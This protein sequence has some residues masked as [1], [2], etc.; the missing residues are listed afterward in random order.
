MLPKDNLNSNDLRVIK[1]ARTKEAINAAAAAGF[2]PLVKPGQPLQPL[3][4]LPEIHRK[5]TVLQNRNTGEIR[6]YGDYR[7]GFPGGDWETAVPWIKYYPHSFPS[8]YA[9]CL[10]PPDLA[11][12]EHVY[13]EDLIEDYVGDTWNQGDVFRLESCEAIWNGRN[14]EIQYDAARR[15]DFVG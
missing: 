15:S 2:R 1:T 8:P 7:G 4:P 13:G 9:A 12:G 5:F 10:I 6:V 3:Q 14:L 11:P